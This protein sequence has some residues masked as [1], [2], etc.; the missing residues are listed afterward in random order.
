MEVL[1]RRAVAQVR[2]PAAVVRAG[3]QARGW[4]RSRLVW[5]TGIAG[6]IKI[7]PLIMVFQFTKPT[8]ELSTVA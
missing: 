4:R 8:P 7:L 5:L 2:P 1:R 6:I 3:W